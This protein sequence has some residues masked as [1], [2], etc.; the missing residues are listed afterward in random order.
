MSAGAPAYRGISSGRK[1]F[2]THNDP[3]LRVA[4]KWGTR[5]T[6][7]TRPARLFMGAGEGLLELRT[8]PSGKRSNPCKLRSQRNHLLAHDKKAPMR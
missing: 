3:T 6:W 1:L 8:P 7:G 2:C 5:I 4:Q